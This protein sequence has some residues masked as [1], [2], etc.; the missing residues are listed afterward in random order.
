M[1]RYYL[2]RDAQ[3]RNCSLLAVSAIN[4]VYILAINHSKLDADVFWKRIYVRRHEEATCSTVSWGEATIQA[5]S[6]DMKGDKLVFNYSFDNRLY[7]VALKEI[8]KEV[9]G[10][11]HTKCEWIESYGFE[12]HKRIAFCQQMKK[13]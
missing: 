10:Q 4:A 9:E 3:Y 7:F 1:F 6:R 5:P 12:L 2:Q 13:S 8:D 11:F